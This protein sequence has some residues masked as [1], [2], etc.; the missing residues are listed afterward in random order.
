MLATWMCVV[1]VAGFVT[2]YSHYVAADEN[3]EVINKGVYIGEV[4]VS[5]MTAKE[6]KKAVQKYVKERGKANITLQIE[7]ESITATAKELGF[8]WKNKTVVD[9]A[10]GLGKNGNIIKRYTEKKD[11]EKENQFL[12][13]AEGLNEKKATEAIEK[14]CAE[15]NHPAEN[16]TLTRTGGEFVITEESKGRI[17]DIEGCIESITEVLDGDWDGTDFTIM[18]NTQSDEPDLTY[19]DCEKV[20]DLLGSFSTT[21]STG[22]YNANR[23][24]N[25]RNGAEKLGDIV[26]APDEEYSCNALLEPWTEDNGWANAGTYVDGRVE[27]SLGG[28]ICQVSSTLYNAL[29]LAELEITERYPHSMAVGYV[30]LSADAAL[31]GTYKD[32][33]FKNNTESPIYIESIYQE[34]KVTFNIYGE[35]TRAANRTIKYV[36][37]KLSETK[38]EE[39]TSKDHY[40]KKGEKVITTNGHTGYTARLWK[41]VYEDGVEVSKEQVNS[42]TYAMSPTYIT[43]G[44]GKKVQEETKSTEEK[45]TKKEEKT[46]K[47]EEET[48]TTAPAETTTKTPETTTKAPET[49]TSVP[50]TTTPVPETTTP[51]PDESS[52]VVE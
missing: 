42:S 34:G 6:A 3:E 29:L 24:Q 2:G 38:P 26:L 21:F 28:G 1:A 31:A 33:K 41:Y 18:L 35:E 8:A 14:L 51:V 5:G 16:A 50:E 4:N 17:V 30:D 40:M 39:I 20:T 9:E 47:S 10:V 12:E 19:A 46:K 37:E 43:V 32:L 45:K 48:T 52:P 49:T 15:Y 13:L 25:I 23:N 44:T 22:S 27:D 11:L 36:S 7:D